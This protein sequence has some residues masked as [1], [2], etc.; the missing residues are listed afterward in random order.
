MKTAPSPKLSLNPF[1]DWPK[2]PPSLSDV[3]G[4]KGLLFKAINVEMCLNVISCGS[5]V[6]LEHMTSTEELIQVT[7]SNGQ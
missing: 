3:L 6:L 5:L 7:F 4:L 1:L 2:W